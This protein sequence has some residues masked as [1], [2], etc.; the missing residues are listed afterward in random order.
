VH[1]NASTNLGV[2]LNGKEGFETDLK[3]CIDNSLNEE[4]FDASW[5]AMIDRHE[6]C[7][8]KYM[9]HLYDNRKKWVPCFFMDYFFPFMSTSQRSE[10]MNKLFKDFVH[11]ADLIRNF[12]FQYE[13]L[14]QSCLDRDDNQ[15]FIT[16]QTDPKMWS[17]YPMEE[18]D[19]KFYTRAMFE[20]F[21]EMLYRATKYK[22]IN[23]PEPGSYF[24][25]LI[26]DDDNKKFLVHYDINNEIYSCACKKFQRD[27]ILCGHVLKVMTQLNVY[28]A[29]EKYMC[30]RW[31]LR[32]SEHATSTLVPAQNDE[33]ASRKMRYI[34]LCKKSATLPHNIA[35]PGCQHYDTAVQACI[36]QRT[37][38]NIELDADDETD[39]PDLFHMGVSTQLGTEKL[40]EVLSFL[41]HLC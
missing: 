29:P 16:V 33:G 8:N 11:P 27:K 9:Q 40:L 14:A 17:G 28:V 41:G 22:T 5:D 7:G 1:R 31:T 32:G 25:Q 6:L 36:D 2:L 21:Q 12:I 23:G 39:P 4:E 37:R 13:K 3:S 35:F 15:R 34:S 38:W 20:E 24:V 30:D 26:L 10:S 19:S 18:Q